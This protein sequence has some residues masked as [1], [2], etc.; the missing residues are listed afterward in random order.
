VG[1]EERAL[2]HEAEATLGVEGGLR[3]LRAR[4]AADAVEPRQRGV[5]EREARAEE[6]VDSAVGLEHDV[7]DEGARLG[8]HRRA[9]LLAE[10][11][12]DGGVLL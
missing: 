3:Q 9:Q 12:V 1:G 10:A 2:G 6:R 5:D 11:A 4:D 8:L 7:L